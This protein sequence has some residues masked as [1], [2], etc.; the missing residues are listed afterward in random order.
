MAT[1]AGLG[2]P[3]S[4]GGIHPA[5]SSNSALFKRIP[6]SKFETVKLSFGAWIRQSGRGNPRKGACLSPPCMA[7][8]AGLGKPR[9]LWGI[10]P[11]NSSNSA[12]FKRIPPSKFETVKLSFGA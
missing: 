1:D 9:S 6:P 11:A 4:L 3:R 5:N 10:H 12:L 8:D 7:T 2:K